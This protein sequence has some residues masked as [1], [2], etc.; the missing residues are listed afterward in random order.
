MS[1]V[2][3]VQRHVEL[4]CHGVSYKGY[5]RITGVRFDYEIKFA[6]PLNEYKPSDTPM[7]VDEVREKFQITVKREGKAIKLAH[8]EFGFFLLVLAEIVSDFYENPLTCILSES[9]VKSRLTGNTTGSPHF[10][11]HNVC[12]TDS[13]RAVFSDELCQMLSDPKFGCVFPDS[14]ATV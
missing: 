8:N 3:W 6:V 11:V 4:V 14:L 5:I 2:A 13:I 9:F 12:S 10:I 7:S 1:K